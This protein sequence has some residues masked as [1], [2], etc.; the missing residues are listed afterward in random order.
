MLVP[1][2][3]TNSASHAMALRLIDVTIRA[4]IG[5]PSLLQSLV[6]SLKR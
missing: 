4:I 3:A 2:R 6:S 1:V 5:F